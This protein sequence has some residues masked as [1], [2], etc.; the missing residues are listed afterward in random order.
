MYCLVVAYNKAFSQYWIVLY[1]Q[2]RRQS[3]R[4]GWSLVFTLG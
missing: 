4:V 3:K 2:W 1:S